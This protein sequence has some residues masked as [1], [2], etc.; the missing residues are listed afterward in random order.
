M[1]SPRRPRTIM[2]VVGSGLLAASVLVAGR[3]SAFPGGNGK[4]AF[5]SYV[6][7]STDIFSVDPDGTNQVDLTPGPGI[8]ITPTWSPDGTKIAFG[9]T[10]TGNAEIF[11]MNADG[12]GQSNRTQSVGSD[13][14]PTW[15]P[16]G[17]KIAFSTDR[18]GDTEI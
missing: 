6:S 8:D 18:D 13:A 2:L 5:E 3:T 16:D 12:S 17:T 4:I 14:D 7:A 1:R 10:R 9:S 11:T 15:S